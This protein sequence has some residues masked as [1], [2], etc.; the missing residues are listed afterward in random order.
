M[1]ASAV[2][3][4]AVCAQGL[5]A[6]HREL[7]DD[8]RVVRDGVVHNKALIT[9]EAVQWARTAVRERLA[10]GGTFTWTALQDALQNAQKIGPDVSVHS[11]RRAM[12]AAGFAVFKTRS[13]P[14]QDMSTD[15]WCRQRERFALEFAQALQEERAGESVMVASDESFLNVHHRRHIT[16]ADGTAAE[17]VPTRRGAPRAVVRM[18]S[19]RGALIIIKHAI[20]RAGWLTAP[21]ADG[22]VG[23]ARVAPNKWSGTLA[24]AEC[25]YASS[26]GRDDKDDYHSH[27]DAQN[28]L[29]WAKEQLFPAFRALYGYEKRMV[30]LYD[31]SANHR[32][33]A[34]TH[35]PATAASGKARLSAALQAA[36]VRSI[37]VLRT[38]TVGVGR[39]KQKVEVGVSRDASTWATTGRAGVTVAELVTAL[40]SAY[41]ANPALTRNQMEDLFYHGVWQLQRA[42]V[43]LSLSMCVCV[44]VRCVVCVPGT[45]ATTG[46]A[47]QS[48]WLP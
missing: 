20:T 36:G 41:A 43:T 45:T 34:P 37:E 28:E 38:E 42:P 26:W 25:V 10:V 48:D 46:R 7:S 15:Y 44:C 33:M 18:N 14:P 23:P 5:A 32:C 4:S 24:N 8:V 13:A 35:C 21:D 12:I 19:G 29:K 40:K 9:S 39:H 47:T 11:V 3:A 31:N 1:Y 2:C 27:W 30:L 22:V 16:V 17:V 6:P